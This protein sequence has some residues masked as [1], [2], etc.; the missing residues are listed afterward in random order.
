MTQRSGG[1]VF[2]A[3]S[4]PTATT[5]AGVQSSPSWPAGANPEGGESSP[6]WPAGANPERVQSSPS[7]PAGANPEG[8]QS[9]PSWPAGANPEGG[10][11]SPSWLAEP[12]PEGGAALPVDTPAE[13]G[14]GEL[15]GTPEAG[16]PMASP[17]GAA[18]GATTALPNSLSE[19]VDELRD[20]WARLKGRLP[21]PGLTPYQGLWLS[22][23][24]GSGLFVAILWFIGRHLS[25]PEK[26]GPRGS[27]DWPLG[28]ADSPPF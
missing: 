3:T 19:A 8:V 6:S 22:V 4:Q 2:G 12:S 21:R 27:G 10:E 9:S 11:S 24:L 20:G 18:S 15:M 25:H 16:Q 23:F 14:W 17:E 5:P 7:W 28:G 13:R 1:R 26:G